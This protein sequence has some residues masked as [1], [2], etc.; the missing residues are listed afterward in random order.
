L[1]FEHPVSGQRLTFDRPPPAD[2]ARLISLLQIEPLP[3][4]RR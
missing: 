1:G 3:A 4:G 2:L